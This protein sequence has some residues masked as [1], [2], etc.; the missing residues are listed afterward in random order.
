MKK[1]SILLPFYN[2]EETI[3]KL[4]EELAKM[5]VTME[6]KYIVEVICV[7]DGSKDKTLDKLLAI[8]NKDKRY[9]IINFS[10]NFGQ[11]VALTAGLDYIDSD[12]TIIM[13]SDLQDPPSVALELLNKWEEGY[14]VVYAQRRQ[15]QG[16]TFF[17][18][19]TSYAFYRVLDVFANIRIPK[20]TGDFRLI[21]RKVVN[22]L[23][24]FKERNRYM[25]GLV[26]Y[27]GFKQ[28]AVL[29]DRA[30]R[31]AGETK[32]P[33]RKMIGLALDA[34]TGFSTVPL[35]LI[36][37]LGFFVSFLS[38]MGVGY[39]LYSKFFLADQTVS[40]WTFTVISIFFIGGVQM[41]MLGI[42]GT[43]I[44]RIYFEVQNRPLYIVSS[45]WDDDS[46]SSQD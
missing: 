17:K 45:I 35:E 10:R 3:D 4:Y 24:S 21:D 26:S 33:L 40:G 1:I 41:I 25:R 9:K 31:Y 14:E 38:F 22:A 32:W 39:A 7:N 43:Y 11:Q 27:V 19:F 23:K 44:G 16:E 5:I 34:I 6:K 15:R 30:E 18:K 12:A 46:K 2:E 20:D 37:K 8:H 36:T 13:D 42:L 28:T 29:F